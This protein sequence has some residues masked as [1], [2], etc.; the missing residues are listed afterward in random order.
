MAGMSGMP[1]MGEMRELPDSASVAPDMT[2]RVVAPAAGIYKLWLQFRG[3]SR[4]YVTPFI[5]TAR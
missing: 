5:L 3:G 1:G 4:L 2:L